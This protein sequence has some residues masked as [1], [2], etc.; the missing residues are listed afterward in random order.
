MTERKSFFFPLALIAAG[1]LWLAVNLGRVPAA[2]LWALAYIWPYFLIATGVGLILR[3]YWAG[4]SFFVSLLVVVGAVLAI[5]YAPALGWDRAPEWG[6]TWVSRSVEGGTPGSGNI[7]GV[8]RNVGEFTEISILYPSDVTIRQGEV[9]SVKITADDNLLPQLSTEVRSG[10]LTIEN[11]ERSWAKRVNSTEP[12]QIIITVNDLSQID[13]DSAGKVLVDQLSV[14]ELSLNLSGAGEITFASLAARQLTVTIS[15]A[16]SIQ[17]DGNAETLHLEID[18]LGSFNGDG[19]YA[20]NA[21][22]SING[23]GSATL[24]VERQLKAEING[25]GSI[26]YYGSPDVQKGINGLGSV[27]RLGD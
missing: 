15:G 22:I 24:H 13:F 5:L 3:S 17:A 10:R 12:V 8:A 11:N 2:N 27:K 18:G 6:W 21:D 4:A 16:G 26:N 20:T 19:F 14:D 23:A 9:Q 7:I 25:A 1:G